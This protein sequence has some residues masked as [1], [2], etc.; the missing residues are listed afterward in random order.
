M[1]KNIIDSKTNSNS[2]EEMNIELEL[3]NVI[4]IK[5][6]KN[7][8]LNMQTFIIDYIDNQKMLLTNV[9]TFN[10]TKL[11]INP[12]G[13]IAVGKEDWDIDKPNFRGE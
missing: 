9:D 8:K 11:K 2:N 3:G 10:S 6:P 4:R 13:T 7:E 5:S 12:D 1:S